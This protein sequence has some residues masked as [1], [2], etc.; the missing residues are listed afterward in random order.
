MSRPEVTKQTFAVTKMYNIIKSMSRKWIYS[1]L[2]DTQNKKRP[3]MFTTVPITNI[4]FR[5]FSFL[6]NTL[7]QIRTCI[8]ASTSSNG[9]WQEFQFILKHACMHFHGIFSPQRLPLQIFVFVVSGSS[10]PPVIAMP[11][12]YVVS[13]R[14]CDWSLL[15]EMKL[16]A[17]MLCCC[18]NCMCRG[19]GGERRDKETTSFLMDWEFDT[20]I[21]LIGCHFFSHFIHLS[22]H[23]VTSYLMC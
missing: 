3:N 12:F 21:R 13:L 6:F 23:V 8:W 20:Q 15:W 4:R 16:V 1:L 17:Q 18:L 14:T 2:Q 9:S 7:M 10:A 5:F 19:W 11:S 22:I